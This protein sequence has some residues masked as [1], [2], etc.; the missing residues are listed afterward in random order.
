MRRQPEDDE[1]EEETGIRR[2]V[3]SPLDVLQ[4]SL[5]PDMLLRMMPERE[6]AQ[7]AAQRRTDDSAPPSSHRYTASLDS[8]RSKATVTIQLLKAAL[9]KAL[10]K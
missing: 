9:R 7:L 10:A 1:P 5:P 2:R 8:E 3:L 6:A 4:A